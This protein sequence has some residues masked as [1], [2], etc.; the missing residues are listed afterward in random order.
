MID[1]KLALK[2]KEQWGVEKQT[3]MAIEEAAE[4]I[5]ARNHYKRG[6]ITKEA[7]VEEMVDVYIMF[8]QLRVMYG[9][10]FEE[11][12][13]KKLHHIYKKLRL[14]STEKEHVFE[15]VKKEKK[16]E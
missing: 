3:E 1:E 2:A 7:Y 16:D 12:L 13:H 11:L 5:L 6:R 8:S 15:I 4:F 9:D 14:Y 10:L